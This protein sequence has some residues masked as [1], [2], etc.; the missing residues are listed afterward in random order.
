MEDNELRCKS[1]LSKGVHYPFLTPLGGL[2]RFGSKEH[3]MRACICIAILWGLSMSTSRAASLP[4]SEKELSGRTFGLVSDYLAEFSQPD[5]GV[6]Y[7]RR[8]ATRA[9]WKYSPADIRAG[10]PE[11]WGY[12]SHIEDTA[13]HCG[14]MLSAFLDA[15]TAK[16]D[17][18]LAEYARRMY[19]ALRFI[20]SSSPVPGL[21]PRGPHPDDPAAVYTDSSMDQHTTYIIAMALYALSPLASEE[22][23]AFIGKS[24]DETGQRL[25][26]HQY[27]IK[28]P[29]GVTE[30]HV[31]FSW[32]G[33]N[34]SHAQILLPTTYALY[35]GT[36]DPA[37]QAEYERLASESNGKRWD[38][39][40][41]G[42]RVTLNAHPIYTNQNSFRANAFYRMLEDPER[43]STIKGLLTQCAEMQ[44]AREYPGDFC[45]RFN[46]PE[47]WEALARECG[48]K[49]GK[50]HSAEEAWSLYSPRI[51]GIA[52][53]KV[54]AMAMEAHVRFPLGGYHMVVTSENP[55]LIRTYA[56]RIWEMINTIDLSQIEAGEINYI[57][58]AIAL[59]LYAS[60][61]EIRE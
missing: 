25:R 55:G 13:L 10:K 3:A 30:A 34:S 53:G 15:Y 54:R 2:Y 60:F 5:T 41:P 27:S 26:K 24:L 18:R 16:P 17:P 28:Q 58:S 61:D 33:L 7:G 1:R 6:L 9:K 36:G 14:H 50:L 44:L 35:K 43:K 4:F 8:L 31:G 42:D 56:A 19:R 59:H 47:K 22:E 46:P 29:D 40:Q 49:G 51:G 45:Y 32:L 20:Y 48:W 39:L 11:P 12:G 52:D 38:F 21:V 23:K 37:W 57:V